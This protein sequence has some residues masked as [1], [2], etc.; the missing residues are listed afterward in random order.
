MSPVSSD[1]R[2]AIERREG[3]T[4]IVKGGPLRVNKKLDRSGKS[5]RPSFRSIS[6]PRAPAR[7]RCGHPP[8]E[9]GI[10][11]QAGGVVHQLGQA[12]RRGP[13]ENPLDGRL[14]GGLVVDPIPVHAVPR[15][16]TAADQNHPLAAETLA[17]RPRATSMGEAPREHPSRPRTGQNLHRRLVEVEGPV[18]GARACDEE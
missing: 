12:R 13:V 9:G 2:G 16:E 1:P 5:F 17:W 11:N 6:G 15:L 7:R 14:I 3:N 10:R 4:M 18:A 8:G